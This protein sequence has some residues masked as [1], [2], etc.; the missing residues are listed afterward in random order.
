MKQMYR[1]SNE[2]PANLFMLDQPGSLLWCEGQTMEEEKETGWTINVRNPKI[3]K[4]QWKT[5]Y[6]F[7][8]VRR[9]HMH[10]IT[11]QKFKRLDNSVGKRVIQNGKVNGE[12]CLLYY[13]NEKKPFVDLPQALAAKKHVVSLCAT[14]FYGC[15][16]STSVSMRDN[17]F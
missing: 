16:Y 10:H 15:L 11:L 2:F 17:N 9:R 8:N 7:H 13:T 14:S 3:P 4:S 5:V 6:V 12:M 1:K